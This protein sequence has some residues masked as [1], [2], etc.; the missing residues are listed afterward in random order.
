MSVYTRENEPAGFAALWETYPDCGHRQ[1][2]VEADH[3]E[4]TYAFIRAAYDAG[5][6]AALRERGTGGTER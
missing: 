1:V 6:Q 4:C 5:R 3:Q 2:M